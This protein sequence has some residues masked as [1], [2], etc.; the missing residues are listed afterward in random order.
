[1][2]QFIENPTIIAVRAEIRPDS[3]QAFVDWQGK[4]N[5]K[6]IAFPGFVSLEFVAPSSKHTEW[7]IVQR[8]SNADEAD[9]WQKSPVRQEI[10]EELKNFTVNKS[11]EEEVVDGASLKGGVT[12]FIVTE[13]S[14]EKEQAFQEW[15]SK[16]HQTEGKFPGFRGL[17][18]QSPRQAKGKYWI[19]LLQFDTMENL[20]RWLDSPERQA[21]LKE[22]TSVI[23]SLEAHRVISPYAGWFASIAK[24]GEL[25]SVWK[26]TMLVLLV[27]FPIELL[28]MK[29]I[30][31]LFSALDKTLALFI[32]SA[33]SVSL[34]A[35]PMLPLAIKCLN[36][37]L[38]NGKK[39]RLLTIGG[40][41]FVIALYAVEIAIFWHFN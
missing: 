13:I 11:I 1:M 2:P 39:N 34:I 37:W 10:F 24:V 33:I 20:D 21:L 4:F 38:S 26:Q 7:R 29:Y 27:L 31:P 36:W 8:F 16:I 22:S 19:T 3:K 9:M 30:M 18:V 6:I 25:P 40:A 32:G 23:S 12:E 15:A 41:L 17:Y 35:Y 5:A 28:E 14:P